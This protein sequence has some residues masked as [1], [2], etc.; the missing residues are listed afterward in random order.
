MWDWEADLPSALTIESMDHTVVGYDIN[1]NVARY[2]R[3]RKIPHIEAGV[4]ELLQKTRL[5]VLLLRDVLYNSEMIFV[6]V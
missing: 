2:I 1:P 4:P 3:N 6:Q 5:K